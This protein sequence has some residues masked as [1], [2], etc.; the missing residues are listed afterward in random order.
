VDLLMDVGLA[1]EH[2]PAAVTQEQ[3]AGAAQI[4]V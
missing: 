2:K 1:L 4:T 3:E